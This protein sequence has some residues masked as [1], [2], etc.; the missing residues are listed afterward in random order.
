MKPLIHKNN[1][2]YSLDHVNK[3]GLCWGNII[4]KQIPLHVGAVELQ[5]VGSIVTLSRALQKNTVN[6]KISKMQKPSSDKTR[7]RLGS[8][9]LKKYMQWDNNV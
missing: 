5:V 4:Q 6:L 9:L 3:T 8:M 2:A 1:G 7:V